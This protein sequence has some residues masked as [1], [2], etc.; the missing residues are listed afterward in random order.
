LV[1]F[2]IKPLTWHKSGHTALS[3]QMQRVALERATLCASTS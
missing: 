1:G 2:L 3:L